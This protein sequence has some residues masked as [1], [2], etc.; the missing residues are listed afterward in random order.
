M[1]DCLS[2]FSDLLPS[3]PK[4]SATAPDVPITARTSEKLALALKHGFAS[5]AAADV[6]IGA[7]NRAFAECALPREAAVALRLPETH[8]HLLDDVAI[9][10]L[11]AARAQAVRVTELEYEPSGGP[12]IVV[13][14]GAERVR[15]PEPP[16]PGDRIIALAANGL[17]EQG[18]RTALAAAPAAGSDRKD[19]LEQIF[20]R[21]RAYRSVLFE[22]L[23]RGLF[24]IGVAVD[25]RG[26]AEGVRKLMSAEVSAEIDEQGWPPAEGL[27]RMLD[28]PGIPNNSRVGMALVSPEQ[29]VQPLVEHVAIWAE[30]AWP[31]GTVRPRA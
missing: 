15:E 16:Q 18:H 29:S 31:I 3:E 7:C 2:R 8:E 22:P 27:E 4:C 10:V 30:A 9:S 25:E 6:V 23:Q 20:S 14:L 19:R 11:R 17:H 5:N 28:A 21:Q 26:L 24:S 12:E 13:Q 1:T